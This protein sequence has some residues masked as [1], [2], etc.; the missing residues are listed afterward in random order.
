MASRLAAMKE[1]IFIS[2]ISL[3]KFSQE[4]E[5]CIL[6][7]NESGCKKVVN[8]SLRK[9]PGGLDNGR[10][11]CTLDWRLMDVWSTR[12]QSYINDHDRLVGYAN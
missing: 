6:E 3:S 8:D 11:K 7:F 4:I 9:W 10:T 5:V 2:T 12:C 1:E